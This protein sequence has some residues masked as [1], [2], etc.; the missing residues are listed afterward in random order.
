MLFSGMAEMV[1]SGLV[2]WLVIEVH[3]VEM[4]RFSMGAVT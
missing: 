1:W 3:H 4:R 2:R